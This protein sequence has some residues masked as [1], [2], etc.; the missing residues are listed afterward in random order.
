MK[1]SESLGSGDCAFIRV[2]SC[3][4]LAF[5]TPEQHLAYIHRTD[6]S[7]DVRGKHTYVSC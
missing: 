1:E 2:A 7:I 6:F 5:W 3:L 4:S